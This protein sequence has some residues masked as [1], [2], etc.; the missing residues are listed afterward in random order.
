MEWD[1]IDGM[2]E[3]DDM[4]LD[5]DE[6]TKKFKLFATLTR[7]S[8]FI[9]SYDGD[10]HYIFVIKDLSFFIKNSYEGRIIQA[11]EK[12]NDKLRETDHQILITDMYER[13][14][15][16]NLEVMTKVKFDLPTE[17]DLN[18]MIIEI[19]PKL[20]EQQQRQ[21]N[22]KNIKKIIDILL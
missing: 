16:E 12:I 3:I 10:S 19:F 13:K 6:E 1:S 15:P 17:V 4:D 18:R 8:H 9:D 22:K 14:I 5:L 20:K 7:I 11:I 2:P 21:L